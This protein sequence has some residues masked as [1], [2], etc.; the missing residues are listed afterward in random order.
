MANTPREL[1]YKT[2]L[3]AE[4]NSSHGIDELLSNALQ[5]SELTQQE[6]RWSME[7]V[8]GVTRMKLQLD[9]WITLAFK[10]RYRKAQHGVKCLLRMG[11]FQ[12]KHM[13]TSEHAAINETVALSRR[14]KQAQA[15]GLVNAVLRKI[16]KLELDDLLKHSSNDIQRLSVETSHPQ[17]LLHKWISRYAQPDVY[18]LC[19]HN[20][21]A[22]LIWIRR[23][24]QVVG[25]TDFEALLGKLDITFK[26][27][28]VLDVFYEISSASALFSTQEFHAGWFSFQDLAAGVVA[29]LLEPEAGDIIVDTCAAPGG[30]M[31]FMSEMSGGQ[32][33]IIACDASSARLSRVRENIQRLGLK[34]I[35]VREL[36][37]AV[38]K[39]PEANK[40][41]LDVP[42]SGTGV[43]NRR[44]DARWKRQA[45]DIDSLVNIQSHIL[46]NSWKFLKPGGLLVY[47]T[48][49]LEPEENW[50]L[51]DQ[52]IEQLEQ[53]KVEAIEDEILKP[54]ID[55]RGALSTLP[56]THRMDG[57]FAVKIRKMT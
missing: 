31:A 1:A 11:V 28:E 44:P 32:A 8:Y 20:N 53:A 49:T 21:T 6:K 29:S 10:G 5:Q 24:V 22:P 7:L 43:L 41:L 35:E 48:C 56:W 27:S 45:S 37:A 50:E 51:V 12:L 38:D 9:E 40:I 26:K 55:E 54:Y 3:A 46:T 52:V 16:Q 2:L 15:S 4:K 47:A 30:K 33:S 42:C 19:Q 13:Q 39:L 14:V 18:S 34:Q 36:D 17:W 25:A 23:N 57:M